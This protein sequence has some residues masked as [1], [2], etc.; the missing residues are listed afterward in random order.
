MQVWI[1]CRRNKTTK[2][3]IIIILG[4]AG[5]NYSEGLFDEKVKKKLDKI[6]ITIF[7]IHGNHEQRASEIST[8]QEIEW[9]G[10]VVY[11]ENKHP[12]ILFAKDAEVYVL[13]GKKSIAIGGAYSIDKYFRIRRC[14]PWYANEQPD[15]IIKGRVEEKLEQNQWKIDVVLSHTVPRKYEPSEVFLKRID[16]SLVDKT[17]ENW[18]D[19]IEDRLDYSKWYAGHYHTEKK[20][21]K[22][23]ILYESVEEFISN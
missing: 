15:E 5:I 23:Q 17:T 16:Q 2:D 3:D 9:N 13:N 7:C 19:L 10:G 12:S 14:M 22:L 21:E 11:I 1:F 6:P 4:D 18:L 20:I 8:Y